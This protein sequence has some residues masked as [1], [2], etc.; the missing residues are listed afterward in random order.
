MATD[1]VV[2]DVASEELAAEKPA[3]AEK[4]ETPAKAKGE[5]KPYVRIEPRLQK[6]YRS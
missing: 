3:K 2:E 5:K 6:R 1:V 4:A